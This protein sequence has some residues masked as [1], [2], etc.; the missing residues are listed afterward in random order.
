M[1]TS[2]ELSLRKDLTSLS[3]SGRITAGIVTTTTL[4]VGTAQTVLTTSGVNVGVG[5]ASPRAK[6]DVDGHARF[7]T[8]SENVGILS[9]VSNVVTVDLSTAQSFIC[10]ATANISQF[11]L[12]NAPSGSTEFTIRIAQDGTGSRSVGIDTFKTS[13]GVD[14]PVFWPGGG[15]LPIVTPTASRSD[16]YT[17]KTFDGDNLTTSGLYGVVVGQNFAN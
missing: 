12:I 3:S 5:T 1:L 9:I 8:Y 2:L 16:I 10:T 17:F 11:T 4:N 15:V 7:R 14:I 6:F 13:G